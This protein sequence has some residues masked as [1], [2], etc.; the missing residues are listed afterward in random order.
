MPLTIA[1]RQ[2]PRVWKSDS[3]YNPCDVSQRCRTGRKLRVDGE[4][5]M[6]VYDCGDIRVTVYGNVEEE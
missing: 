4:V 5:G 1:I 2:A 6:M 3:I